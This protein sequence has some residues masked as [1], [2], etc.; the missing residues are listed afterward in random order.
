M[1]RGLSLLKEAGPMRRGLFPKVNPGINL[2]ICLP[3]VY[4]SIYASLLYYL[5]F[6]INRTKVSTILRKVVNNL[7]IMRHNEARPGR[8]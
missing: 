1:R 8:F 5:R 3:E 2:P 4:L 7:G 6:G